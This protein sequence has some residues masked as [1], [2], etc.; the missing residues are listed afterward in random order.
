M[1]DILNSI[2]DLN[3]QLAS[4]ANDVNVAKEALDAASKAHAT[5]EAELA[6][7]VKSAAEDPANASLLGILRSA[8]RSSTPKV[9]LASAYEQACNAQGNGRFTSASLS[10]LLGGSTGVNSTRLRKIAEKGGAREVPSEGK[11]KVY[12][13]ITGVSMG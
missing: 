13:I 5:L 3:T 9:T 10:E 6:D 2:N 12:E 4:A 8:S 7:L 1:S 11:A